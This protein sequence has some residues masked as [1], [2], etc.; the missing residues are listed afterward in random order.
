M[1]T[2]YITIKN[3][4]N[5]Y[6]IRV[7]HITHLRGYIQAAGTK[8]HT[9]INFVGGGRLD[10]VAPLTDIQPQIIGAMAKRS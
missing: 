6:V 2:E 10:L 3:A 7:E 8:A 9:E 1:N 4:G 5:D